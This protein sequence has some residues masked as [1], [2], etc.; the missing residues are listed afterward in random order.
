MRVLVV[1]DERKLAEV[2]ERGLEEHGYAV[3]VAHDGDGALNLALGEPTG[4]FYENTFMSIVEMTFMSGAP[5]FSL[6]DRTRTL[7]DAMRA[8]HA[9]GTTSIFEEHG[10]ASELLRTYKIVREIGAL[11]M[12]ST[13]VL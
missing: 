2:L 7:P 9:F 3:D 11:T 8:Y 6:N 5:G 4:I 12:R 10:V 13:L 1:E